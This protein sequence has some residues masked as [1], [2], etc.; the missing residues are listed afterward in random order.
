MIDD[1]HYDV[2]L[3]NTWSILELLDT[4]TDWR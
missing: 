1:M 4:Y 3:L 2:Q